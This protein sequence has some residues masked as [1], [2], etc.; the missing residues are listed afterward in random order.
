MARRP[1]TQIINEVK[2]VLEKHKELS[3]KAIAKKTKAQW[4]TVRKALETMRDLG[5]VKERKNVHKTGVDER[6]FSLIRNR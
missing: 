6:L 4:R 2:K 3:I 5:L 1:I